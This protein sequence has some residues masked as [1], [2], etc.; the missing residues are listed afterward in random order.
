MAGSTKPKL[1]V[2]SALLQRLALA[3]KFG[4]Q[5]LGKR[6]L[7]K[8]FGYKERLE[9]VDFLAKYVRQDI[10]KR[11][12]DAPALATWRAFPMVTADDK[13]KDTWD[14]LVADFLVGNHLE[15]I[16][17]LAGIGQYAILLLG[18]DEDGDLARPMEPRD[19]RSL[20]LAFSSL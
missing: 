15:R 1:K 17:R 20:T 19:S 7:V 10:A 14:G 5:F 16:D 12:V 2:A 3:S 18:F 11:V 8:V 13:F 4:L 9:Y 6:D